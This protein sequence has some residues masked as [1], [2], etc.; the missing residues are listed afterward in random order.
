MHQTATPKSTTKMATKQSTENA[1]PRGSIAACIFY[2]ILLVSCSQDNSKADLFDSIPVEKTIHF[3]DSVRYS[4]ELAA[5]NNFTARPEL[6]PN[7]YYYDERNFFDSTKTLR[8]YSVIERWDTGDIITNYYYCQNNLIDVSKRIKTAHLHLR[9]NYY[10]RKDVLFDIHEEA[11]LTEMTRDT[12][13]ARGYR[14]LSTKVQV[15]DTSYRK[16]F[17]RKDY[18]PNSLIDLIK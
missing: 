6:N 1:M 14:N 17:G 4:I 8:E 5:G 7:Q 15:G 16:Y 10:I 3:I 11:R 13:L 12:I 2:L 9:S 18:P